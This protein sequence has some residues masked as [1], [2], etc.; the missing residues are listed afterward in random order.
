MMWVFMVLIDPQFQTKFEDIYRDFSC[1]FYLCLG[2]HD[3]GN[4]HYIDDRWKHQIEY[5]KHSRKWN[6][7]ARYYHKAF[8]TIDFLL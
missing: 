2:N 7:P 6:M 5:S 1:P 4:G 8:G 3:Y